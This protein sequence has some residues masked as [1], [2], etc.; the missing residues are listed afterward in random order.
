MESKILVIDAIAL[1]AGVA[2]TLSGYESRGYVS[3]RVVLGALLMSAAMGSLV[4][5]FAMHH[6]L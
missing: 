6:P 2:I 4:A 5:L 3:G 1:I